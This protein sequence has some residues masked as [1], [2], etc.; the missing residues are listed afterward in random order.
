MLDAVSTTRLLTRT[1]GDARSKGW[2]S[3][4]ELPR[5]KYL[6]SSCRTRTLYLAKAENMANAS[7]V[8]K[9]ARANSALQATAK[10]GP[11][12]SAGVVSRTRMMSDATN[13]RAYG[14]EQAVA[15][16]DRFDFR[17]SSLLGC[18]SPS[19]RFLWV[20]ARPNRRR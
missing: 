20:V 15:A 12:L 18:G 5:T 13:L 14:D 1:T 2:W 4:A 9:P 6:N 3:S 8:S 16:I 19:A 10:I 11:R 17:L 7:L